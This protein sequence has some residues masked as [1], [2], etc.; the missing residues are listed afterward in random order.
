MGDRET[1][2]HASRSRA[3]PRLCSEILGIAVKVRL[4][5]L[6]AAFATLLEVLAFAVHL[7]V[8]ARWASPS[9]RVPVEAF[10]AEH[11]G[12]VNGKHLSVAQP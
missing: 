9:G 5:G 2:Y 8:W 6:Q 7:R 12:Q 11:Q 4:A 10:E 1:R 3:T